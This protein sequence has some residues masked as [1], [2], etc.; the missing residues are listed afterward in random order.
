MAT[1]TS[2]V[3]RARAALFQLLQTDDTLSTAKAHWGGLTPPDR[4]THDTLMM[5]RLPDGQTAESLQAPKL[6]NVSRDESFTLFMTIAVGRGGYDA[7][8]L[9]MRVYELLGALELALR[10][11]PELAAYADDPIG[12][13][14]RILDWSHDAS[15]FPAL[16]GGGA[17]QIVVSIDCEAT[18]RST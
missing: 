4:K 10:A 6:G 2:A 16:E 3:P 5:C 18:L 14:F 9:D 1:P 12:Q 17:A 7:Q 11:D 8:A 13:P 15:H